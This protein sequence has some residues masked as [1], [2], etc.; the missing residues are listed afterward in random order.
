MLFVQVGIYIQLLYVQMAAVPMCPCIL[1]AGY[2]LCGRL[3]A[4][5]T[6]ASARVYIYR[7]SKV[8]VQFY[9]SVLVLY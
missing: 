4:I 2:C 5:C 6:L 9:V 3:L 7:Y 1:L 8:T